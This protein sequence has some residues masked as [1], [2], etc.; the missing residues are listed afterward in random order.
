MCIRDSYNTATGTPET[1]WLFD[2]AYYSGIVLDGPQ[3]IDQNGGW[4]HYYTTSTSPLSF[5]YNMLSSSDANGPAA[6]MAVAF[7]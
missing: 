3:P 1:N 4:M 6:G 5:T 7:K 2:S